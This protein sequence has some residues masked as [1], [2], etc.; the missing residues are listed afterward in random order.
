[1]RLAVRTTFMIPAAAPSPRNTTISSGAVPR[2]PVERPADEPPYRH[3]GHELDTEPERLA[4]RGPVAL[5]FRAWGRCMPGLSLRQ[6]LAKAVEP[7]PN[8]SGVTAALLATGLF[9][10][11]GHWLC[12]IP[13]EASGPAGP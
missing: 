6:L 12:S 1:M 4:E 2:Q 9:F 11:S 7:L 5:G 10:G 13:G 8:S 3:P